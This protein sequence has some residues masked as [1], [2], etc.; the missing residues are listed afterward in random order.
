MNIL[1]GINDTNLQICLQLDY[2]DILNLKE[3][4]QYFYNILYHNGFWKNYI[5]NKLNEH[6]INPLILEKYRPQIEPYIYSYKTYYTTK[7]IKESIKDNRIDSIIFLQVFGAKPSMC[8]AQCACQYGNVLALDYFCNEWNLLPNSLELADEPK[9]LSD[10]QKRRKDKNMYLNFRGIDG[11]ETYGPRG[12][13]GP[14]GEVGPR[15][16]VGPCGL[17][18]PI[19]I[20][21][22]YAI[23]IAI[24][25]D[26]DNVLE[27]LYRKNI[28]PTQSSVRLFGYGDEKYEKK[29]FQWLYYIIQKDNLGLNIN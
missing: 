10:K 3:T 19:P 13:I 14:R 9:K 16:L 15:G 1:T 5:Y 18:G 25:N 11:G 6:Q 26:H 23:R 2:I 29:A 4:C 12:I 27:W 20:Q 7:S 21:D 8:D 17:V 28:K 22:S 24:E